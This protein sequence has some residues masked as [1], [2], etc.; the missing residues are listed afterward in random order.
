MQLVNL[1]TD[2]RDLAGEINLVAQDLSGQRIRSQ[3]VHCA[4]H[5]GRILLLVI[6]DGEGGGSHGGEEEG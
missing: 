4:S 5:D 6:E 2:I 3:R 1:S